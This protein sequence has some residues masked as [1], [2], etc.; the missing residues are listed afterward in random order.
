[1]A[2]IDVEKFNN[3]ILDI[4][5]DAFK[6]HKTR[7]NIS[8]VKKLLQNT[9]TADADVVEVVRCRDCENYT[10]EGNYLPKCSYLSKPVGL[11]SYCCFGR[12]KEEHRPATYGES[13]PIAVNGFGGD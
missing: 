6:K 4:I 10:Q 3:E 11:N 5:F 13:T 9:P 1:M 7:F 8:E 2:Y 12:K